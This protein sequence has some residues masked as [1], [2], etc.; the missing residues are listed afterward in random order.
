MIEVA[1]PGSAALVLLHNALHWAQAS[2]GRGV[3]LM[4]LGNI[5]AVIAGLRQTA[6]IITCGFYVQLQLG[7]LPKTKNSQIQ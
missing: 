7:R 1:V 3:G 2:N 5:G 6:I 4:W